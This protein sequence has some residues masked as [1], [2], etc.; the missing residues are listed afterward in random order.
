MRCP[1]CGSFVS[2]V[3]LLAGY[4]KIQ[5]KWKPKVGDKIRP[6][7]DTINSIGYGYNERII[8][9]IKGN[10]F[11]TVVCGWDDGPEN[12]WDKDNSIWQPGLD[13]LLELLLDS[14]EG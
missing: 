6:K 14:E 3:S 5:E 7:N 10:N 1:E 11:T 12:L 2:I 4:K 13:D 9:S 8:I